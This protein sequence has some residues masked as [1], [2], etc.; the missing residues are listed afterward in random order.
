MN[1]QKR[2][3]AGIV[4]SLFILFAATGGFAAEEKVSMEQ[5]LK[6]INPVSPKETPPGQAGKK[7]DTDAGE[8]A[9]PRDTQGIAVTI[10]WHMA[11]DA[12]VYLNGKPLRKY[13]PSFKT[14]PDEA[15]HPAFSA[16]ATLFDGDVFTVGGRRGGSFGLMLLAV[17]S[18]GTI[19]FQTDSQSWKVYDPGERIDWFNPQVALASPSGPVTVQSDP[20]YPQKE[21]NAKFGNKAL[22]IWSAPDKTFAYLYGVVS[23]AG[24]KAPPLPE[25]KVADDAGIPDL[26]D[27]APFALQEPLDI[28]TLSIAQYQ[29]AVT[30]AMEA[31]RQTMGELSPE[32]EKRFSAKWGAYFDYSTPESVAY[33]NKLNPLLAEF[34][35]LRAAIATA[36]VEFDGAWEEAVIAAGYESENGIREGLAIA[37]MQKN[38][39]LTM[40]ARLA[41]V[42]K[43]I[44]AVGNPP[45]VQEAKK[46]ARK[47]HQE[48]MKT[49]KKAIKAEKKR[50]EQ[51]NAQAAKDGKTAAEAPTAASLPATPAAGEKP[52]EPI[53]VDRATVDKKY[54]SS[55]F[56]SEMSAKD[57]ERIK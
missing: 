30:A 46:A 1:I 49:A 4:F 2:I 37:E 53:V 57:I 15:P 48:T 14:R 11:D 29:G 34:L 50:E 54:P 43:E 41:Q 51:K 31:F 42:V 18:T 52:P 10:Y 19:I 24:P 21:L 47:K 23:G 16:A 38:Q 33:F 45:D 35:T 39:L 13:E 3:A 44:T 5:W 36:A 12:D 55:N 9:K 20:W 17:D 28:H 6:I 32:E 40:Q 7:T 27:V 26:Q 8:P 56:S 25:E 22:S